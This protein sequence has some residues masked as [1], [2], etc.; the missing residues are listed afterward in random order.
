MASKKPRG[1]S[2][3][4]LVKLAGSR[5][6]IHPRGL[7][8]GPV[9]LTEVASLTVRVRSCSRP[10]ELSKRV[11][12][13]YA[14]P[15][16]KRKYMTREELAELHG[17][18]PEDLD[19]VERFA[20]RHKL[21]VRFR[22]AA[23]RTVI[24]RGTLGDLLEAFPADV[25]MFRHPGMICRGRQGDIRIPKELDKIITGIFGFDTRPRQR[26]MAGAVPLS[27]PGAF[28]GSP[29]PTSPSVTTFRNS[30]GAWNS[31]APGNASGSLN[32][33][34]A[35]IERTSTYTFARSA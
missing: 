14:L 30:I 31:T 28:R 29:P 19:A 23:H 22:S 16:H 2:S 26:H 4:S 17:A 10:V 25:Q 11:E 8:L 7:A 20:H 6:S 15:L 1:A 13:I 18:L 33:E 27:G 35:S 21:A 24:L 5:R 34:A 9:D 12:E 3:R 32:W